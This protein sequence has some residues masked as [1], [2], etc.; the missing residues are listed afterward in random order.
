MPLSRRVWACQVQQSPK[1]LHTYIFR[2]QSA[3]SGSQER[4]RSRRPTSNAQYL[5]HKTKSPLV[6]ECRALDRAPGFS[7]QQNIVEFISIGSPL[8]RS[9]KV[10]WNECK[11]LRTWL[12]HDASEWTVSRGFSTMFVIARNERDAWSSSIVWIALS[13]SYRVRHHRVWSSLSSSF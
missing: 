3:C 1:R 11:A 13:A 9:A 6:L 10:T 8:L 2:S 5:Q 4:F 12:I 7:V